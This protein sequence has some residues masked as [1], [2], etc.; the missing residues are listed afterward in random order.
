MKNLNFSHSTAVSYISGLS[1]FHKIND[2]TDNTQKFVIRK[3]LEGYKRSSQSGKDS[4]LPITREL[5]HKIL[6][7]LPAVCKNKYENMLFSAA[8]SMAFHGFLRVG[9]LTVDGKTGQLHT[10]LFQNTKVDEHQIQLFLATSKTDQC[11]QGTT[12]L[13]SKQQNISTCPV[14][15]LSQY[16]KV[17]P[18]HVGPL[19]CHFDGSPLTRYQFSSVLKKSLSA[20]GIFGNYKSHSFRIGMATTCALEGM[21]DDQIKYLGRWRSGA[22]LKYIRI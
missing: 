16:L 2:L 3:L 13:I 1:Y 7:I 14:K 20:I 17:H 11:G 6:C 22:Y 4:R 8:F 21:P 15:L 19:F 9:E 5:L 12:I 18:K 10:I